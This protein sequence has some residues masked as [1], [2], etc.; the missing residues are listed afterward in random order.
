VAEPECDDGA[1]SA[2]VKKVHRERMPQGMER[3]AFFDQRRAVTASDGQMLVE[4]VFQSV[5]TERLAPRGGKERIGRLP[6]PF[7]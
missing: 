3:D 5:V 7:S 2:V 6:L 4:Q 1:V